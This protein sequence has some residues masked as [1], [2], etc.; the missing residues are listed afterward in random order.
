VANASVYNFNCLKHAGVWIQLYQE[1]S[2]L[3]QVETIEF[4]L[5]TC[6]NLILAH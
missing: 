6:V 5:A 3:T 1:A 4:V 2:D